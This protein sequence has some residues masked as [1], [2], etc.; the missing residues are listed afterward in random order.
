MSFAFALPPMWR[1]IRPGD[2]LILLVGLL[3]VLGLMQHFWL[4]QQAGDRVLIK[5]GGAVFL[6]APLS[7]DRVVDVPGPLGMTRIELM[8][9]RARVAA[10]PG[11]RQLCVRQGW[12][13]RAG[14]VA[15]CLPNQV[16]LEII[17]ASPAYDSLNY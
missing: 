14:D 4:N 6:E 8:H 7:R 5:Q 12:V 1:L 16:S 17:G 9:H 13:S 2:W 10:D 11:P 15:I 3:A